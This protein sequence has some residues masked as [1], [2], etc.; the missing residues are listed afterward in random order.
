MAGETTITRMV[1]ES[2]VSVIIH[3][4]AS[5]DLQLSVLVEDGNPFGSKDMKASD[6]FVT[7]EVSV[8]H[9]VGFRACLSRNVAGQL[10]QMKCVY[11][12]AHSMGKKQEDWEAIV[13]QENYDIV[14][15][16][17]M[18]WDALYY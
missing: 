1:P 3:E 15:I 9:Q 11:L 12:N 2:S 8:C 5:K 18:W 14:I 16:T 4:N 7:T 17:E 10:T 6:R 13:Q